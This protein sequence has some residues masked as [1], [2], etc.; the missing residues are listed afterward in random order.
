MF[1]L[2]LLGAYLLRR[3]VGR[4]PETTLQPVPEQG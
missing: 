4:V 1:G 2:V 3:M